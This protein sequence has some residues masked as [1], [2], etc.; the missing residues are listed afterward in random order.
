MIHGALAWCM[1]GRFGVNQE[2]GAVAAF[3]ASPAAAHIVGDVIH[4]NGGMLFGS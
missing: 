3:L 4:V 1:Q 2:V